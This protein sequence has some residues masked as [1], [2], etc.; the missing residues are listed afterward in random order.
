MPTTVTAT[1]IWIN[2]ILHSTENLRLTFVLQ[3]YMLDT[4]MTALNIVIRFIS[5]L[6]LLILNNCFKLPLKC[7]KFYKMLTEKF[8]FI[9]SLLEFMRN[10]KHVTINASL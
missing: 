2:L 8:L 6:Q 4:Q 1:V 9:L 10:S 3:L 5:L 7:I